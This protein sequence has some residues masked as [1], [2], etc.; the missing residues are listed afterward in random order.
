MVETA[1]TEGGEGKVPP[2]VS[3]GEQAVSTEPCRLSGGT[4]GGPSPSA[5]RLCGPAAP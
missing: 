1:R 2:A 5:G 3:R 4:R